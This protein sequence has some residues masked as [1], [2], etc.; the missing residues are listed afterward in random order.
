SHRYRDH[1]PAEAR[2]RTYIGAME[3]A[4]LPCE[5]IGTNLLHHTSIHDALQKYIAEFGCPEALVCVNDETAMYV[6]R[7]LVD[8]GFKIP[9]NTFLLGCDG[10]P[11]MNCFE[12]PLSTIAQPT[13]EIC[14]LAWQFLK[15]RMANPDLPRQEATFDAQL[16]VRKSMMN[17]V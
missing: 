5:L 3:R 6:Y 4:G 16:V 2:F 15:N 9:D 8:L 17:L 7:A 1:S 12:P 14:A 10:L 13:E 11:F